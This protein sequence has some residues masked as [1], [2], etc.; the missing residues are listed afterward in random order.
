MFYRVFTPLLAPLLT[1][2]VTIL[3]L[4][5][6]LPLWA[7][8]VILCI[9]CTWLIYGHTTGWITVAA[10][11]ICASI[12]A[13]R[14]QYVVTDLSET[15]HHAQDSHTQVCARIHDVDPAA[16]TSKRMATTDLYTHSG[17]RK[18]YKVR[19]TPTQELQPDD[20][21]YVPK[22]T[23]PYAHSSSFRWHLVREQLAGYIHTPLR[24]VHLY[25]PTWS[26][27]RWLWH[28]REKF[29]SMIYACV[30]QLHADII[31]HIF[32]GY[33]AASEQIREQFAHWGVSH[34]LARSGLHLITFTACGMLIFQYAPCYFLYKE[35]LVFFIT[36]LYALLSWPSV[37][38]FRAMLMLSGYYFCRTLHLR[39]HAHHW[40]I[41]SAL[42][43]LCYNPFHL[44]FIDF[45]LSVTLTFALCWRFQHRLAANSH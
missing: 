31:S 36:L 23:I 24:C 21:I 20:V 26:I 4:L 15:Q 10:S 41:L 42:L 45:Q 14:M 43:L 16:A 7:C 28:A 38:F 44:F 13:C 32:L 3:A 18:R 33:K 39:Y 5:H 37:S 12:C 11:V 17:K 27:S 34:M 29:I 35:L 25:R 8:G 22:L 1:V 9:M 40:C 2:I 6:Y 19:I 30:P